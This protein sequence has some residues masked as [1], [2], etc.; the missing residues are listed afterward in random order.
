MV[1]VVIV[2]AVMVAMAAA[3]L[4][5]FIT[6]GD[7]FSGVWSTDPAATLSPAGTWTNESSGLLI[8]RTGT[9]YVFTSVIGMTHSTGWKPLKRHGWVLEYKTKSESFKF[10]YQPWTGH[11]VSAD[12]YDIGRHIVLVLRKVTDSTSIPPQTK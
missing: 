12:V 4:T 8:K 6:I 7:P 11:L 2:A 3:Y 5:G 9:G 1:L 10:E